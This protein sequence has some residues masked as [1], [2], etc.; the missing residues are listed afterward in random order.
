[1]RPARTEPWQAMVAAT[2]SSLSRRLK[3]PAELGDFGGEVGEQARDVGLA[4]RGGDRADQHRGRAEAL[5]L[6]AHA[7]KL[8]RRAFEPVAIG[9]VELDHFGDQQRLA[10]DR[11]ALA[12]GAHPFEHQPLVRG[13]LVDDHQAVLGFGDDIGRGDLPARDAEREARDRLDRGFGAG[14]GGVVEQALVFRHDRHSRESGNAPLAFEAYG[15]TP[16][17]AGMTNEVGI[18]VAL[19]VHITGAAA[20]S[21]AALRWLSS[22]SAWRRPPTI[23]PRTAA[24]S[25]KRTSVLAGWTLTST[26]SSGTSRNKRRD[27]VAVAGDEVAIGGAQG[28]DQQPV[29]HRPRIDEQKLLVGDAAVEGRQADHAGQPQPVAGAVD[30]DAVAVELV[31]QQLGH[32]RRRLGRL[33]A[34]GSAARHDRA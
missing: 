11:A 31:G 32:A 25:R 26:S 12:R 4:E 33:R 23:S 1:M 3:R 15:G 6:E 2:W 7:G 17:F 9:L 16:A 22:S 5:E 10:G 19:V 30:A 21:R 29:L 8:A 13:M 27:R 24:G 34:S 14:G 18:V 28:A 20:C